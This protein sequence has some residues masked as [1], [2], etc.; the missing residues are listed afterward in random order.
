MEINQYSG[1]EKLEIYRKVFD[2]SEM[3][4]GI[5]SWSLEQ[6]KADCKNYNT[7]YFVA[8]ADNKVIGFLHYS[9]IL[10]EFEIYNVATLPIFRNKGVAT[11]LLNNFIS[12]A[13]NVV[14]LE[15]REHNNKAIRLYQAHGFNSIGTRKDY[16]KDPE[17]DAIIMELILSE[18]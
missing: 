16:Y 18:E 14:F 5:H 9:E 3:A 8:E 17:E 12:V 15:V 1:Q 13:D 7:H 4:F 2:C 6:Y 10:N 11:K